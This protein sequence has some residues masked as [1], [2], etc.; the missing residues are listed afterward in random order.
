M[1]TCL[2]CGKPHDRETPCDLRGA[3]SIWQGRY[4]IGRIEEVEE[5]AQEKYNVEQLRHK[6][7]RKSGKNPKE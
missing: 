5:R 1:K 2:L 7:G 4:N 3:D 6:I